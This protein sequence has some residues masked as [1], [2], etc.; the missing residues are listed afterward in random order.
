MSGP[1]R[2]TDRVALTALAGACV[3]CYLPLAVAAGPPLLVA[4]AAVAATGAVARMVA[5]YRERS[6]GRTVKLPP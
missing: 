2:M 1:D 5:R 3:V 4:G 6:A